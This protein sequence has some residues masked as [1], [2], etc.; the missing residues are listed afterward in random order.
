MGR[1]ADMT[2]DYP[3]TLLHKKLQ[4]CIARRI[5]KPTNIQ[6]KA[7]PEILKG[8]NVLLIAPT[9]SG[10]TEAAILPIMDQI[11]KNYWN[12]DGVKAIYINPLKALTRDLR[13]RIEYYAQY[14]GLKVRPLYGDVVKTYR[15]PTPDIIV[16]TPE[17][18][19]VILDWS[20]KWWPYL[21][22]IKWIIVDEIHELLLSKRGYQLLVLLER[23]KEITKKP[24]QRIGLS[25]TIGHPEKI[26]SLLGGS[27][28]EVTIIKAEKER[29]YDFKIMLAIPLSDEEKEDPFLAAARIIADETRS[30]IKTLIFTNSR[31]SAERLQSILD[32]L[33]I[34]CMVHHGS[35]EREERESSEEAFKTGLLRCVIATKTLELGI[36]IGD[37]EQVI[38]Y[39]SPGQV[40]ALIQ[41]A[42]RSKHRP[43]QKSICKI[44]STDP[45]DY[46]ESVAIVSLAKK[47]ILEE[48]LIINKP[49]DVLAKEIIGIALHNYR[50]IK[51][52]KNKF[53]PITVQRAHVI[54][55]RAKIFEKLTLQEFQDVIELLR[56]EKLITLENEILLPG[57][58]FWKVWS[59]NQKEENGIILSFSDFF[60]MIPKRETFVVLEEYGLDKYRKIGELDFDYV[61]RVLST[62]LVI[63]L[64]GANWKVVEIDEKDHRIIVTKTDEKG[65]A[66]VWRGEGPQRQHIVAREMLEIIR[67]IAKNPELLKIY[68]A[69][70]KTMETIKEYIEKLGKEYIESLLQ[71]KIIVEKIPPMKT[72]IFITFAGEHINR[73][74]AAAIYEKIAEKSL[75]M[76][77]VIAPHGFAIR[78]E[79]VD[80][81]EILKE[82]KVEELRTLVE[83]HIYERS[84]YARIILDQM[85][86]HF[87]YPLN[88]KLIYQEAVRQ[89]LLI[90]YDVESAINYIKNL[91]PIREHFVIK[92][93]NKPSELAESILKYP[94]E[95][96]WHGTL[97]AVVKE[98][99]TRAKTVTFD[100]L[101][102]YTWANPF[103][104]KKELEK[105]SKEKPVIALLDTDT[106]GWTVA[107]IPLKEEWVTVRI[108]I[109]VKYFTISNEKDVE[110]YKKEAIEKNSMYLLKSISRGL[111]VEI[112]FYNWDKNIEQKYVLRIN[113]ALP[114]ILKALKNKVRDQLGDV[115]NVKVH[116]KG[117]YITI[118]HA[119]VPTELSDIVVLGFIS[120]IVKIIEKSIVSGK[121]HIVIELP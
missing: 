60:S 116:I 74:L 44:I 100:Q 51:Y 39:R 63:R 103:D 108:P 55:K 114:A 98:A 31:Y 69:D 86:E 1:G 29:E 5:N 34:G 17:S 16:T 49:L 78:S 32:E 53:E 27:D 87:G 104:I 6:L 52:L 40:S 58:K 70:I 115:V 14:V 89:A 73:T 110:A 35:I 67:E 22:T 95:R 4:E 72:T 38:Q 23:L 28:G 36:D 75:L 2:L 11:L 25:A 43:G 57:P 90:Y 84:P 68:G 105:I 30:G 61:Y 24:L 101:L 113:K 19:E 91:Q 13:E 76:K 112:T 66:P 109:A 42:G 77:Y 62:G 102:E 47:K 48:P 18:L 56:N 94:H 97:K 33:D 20:P 118:L 82:L 111:S 65:K 8:K 92:V 81:L 59:F 3:F 37:V 15:K 85:R 96:P 117:T 50:G 64:A 93:M 121:K 41:R 54:I 71:G 119:F 46:L 88:E 10:K 26:A 107:K 83:R 12:I 99:L 106:R 21:K 7:I 79:I 45:E 120:S 80:P 9:A